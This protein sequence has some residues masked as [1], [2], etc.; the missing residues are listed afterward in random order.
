MMATRVDAGESGE[1]SDPED[2][3]V[4]EEAVGGGGAGLSDGVNIAVLVC[5][6]ATWNIRAAGI[7]RNLSF[8]A[9][10]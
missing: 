8:I 3:T 7:I 1:E 5:A 10:R 2:A 6:P 9:N 4:A